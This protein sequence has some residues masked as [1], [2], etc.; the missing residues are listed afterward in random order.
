MTQHTWHAVAAV[1][2]QSS[3]EFDEVLATRPRRMA[4]PGQPNLTKTAEVYSHTIVYIGMNSLS[5]PEVAG[6]GS[7][8][9]SSE[10]L[11][12]RI[13]VIVFLSK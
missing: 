4:F 6:S 2:D 9:S 5:L 11:P 1:A 12:P 10:Q 7:T 8:E 3:T 13:N